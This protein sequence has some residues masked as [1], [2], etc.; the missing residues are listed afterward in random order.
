MGFLTK[1]LPGEITVCG[2]KIPVHCDFRR[3]ILITGLFGEDALPMER[4]LHA[5]ARILMHEPVFHGDSGWMTEFAEQIMW[6]VSCGEPC[7][8]DGTAQEPVFDFDADGDAIFAGFLQ[9][10]GIDLTETH[11]H[12]WKFMALLR[13]LPPET[14]FMRRVELRT[15]DVSKIEDDGMR[16]K[17]RRAKAKIRLKRD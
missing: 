16:K 10:Y 17:L 11:L 15:L 9:T 4:K 1:G 5:A 7:T 3:W 14:E 13:N 2:E 6:F 8:A 12:W